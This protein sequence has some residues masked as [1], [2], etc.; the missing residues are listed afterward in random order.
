MFTIDAHSFLLTVAQ[1]SVTII[2]FTALL[3]AFG[4]TSATIVQDA[5]NGRLLMMVRVSLN[6]LLFSLLPFL[7]SA[8]GVEEPFL[9]RILGGAFCVFGL[10]SM[11]IA[12][13][14]IHQS[15]Y[16]MT[17]GETIHKNVSMVISFLLVVLLVLSA[18]GV[19]PGYEFP[20]Y[21][22]TLVYCIIQPAEVFWFSI[23]ESLRRS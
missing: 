17:K 11:G 14:H 5:Y 1:I 4:K 7:V 3:S 15:E 22:A 18:L 23:S 10:L 19:L 16:T 6:G 8:C 13:N 20:I 2:G 12:H 9:W 21:A